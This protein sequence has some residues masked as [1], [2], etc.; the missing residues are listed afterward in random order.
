MDAGGSWKNQGLGL[1]YSLK[2]PNEN[3]IRIGQ[4]VKVLGGSKTGQTGK[5]LQISDENL[6][7]TVQL[8]DGKRLYLPKALLG[9]TSL[10]CI[11]HCP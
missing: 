9:K 6:I 8:C 3:P 10:H 2:K 11:S 5:L 1:G 4:S 7:C